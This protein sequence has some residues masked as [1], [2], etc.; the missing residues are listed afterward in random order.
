M[1]AEN[2][3]PKTNANTL[4][5]PAT[6]FDGPLLTF[7]FPSF[8]IGIAEYEQGPTGCTVFLFPQGVATAVDVRGGAPGTIGN[9]EWNHAICLAGGSLYGLEAA[10]GVSAELWARR[11]HATD[12]DHI[13]L[14]S[15]AVIYDFKARNS[16]IHPDMDLGRAAVAAAAAGRFYLG[17]RGAGRSATVGKWL[18]EPF[19]PE[20]AGQGGAFRQVGPTKVAVFTVVNSVGVIV[21][22]QGKTLR[23]HYDPATGTRHRI[24]ARA[25]SAKPENCQPTPGNTTLT[26]VVTNQ[27][28]PRFELRQLARQVHSSLARAIDPFHTISDGDVLY[29]ATTAEVDNPELDYYGLSSVAAELAW[30]AVL[31]CYTD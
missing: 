8:Q 14:V 13:A 5:N 10:L 27:N 7:D 25:G 30:D 9:Y 12:W 3:T 15:G 22:R 16:S 4:L 23:G 26:V 24:D 1:P 18:P 11:N 29:A 17:P 6:A 28:L 21:N 19:Q 2:P 20:L 31:S